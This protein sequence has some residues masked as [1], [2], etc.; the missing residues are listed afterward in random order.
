MNI[1]PC[2]LTVKISNADATYI[3]T[4]DVGANLNSI[5]YDLNNGLYNA[6]VTAGSGC[7]VTS[8][9]MNLPFEA[10]SATVSQKL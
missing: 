7:N 6:E 4:F 5:S 1:L 2:D 10:K 9:V 3:N 8:K